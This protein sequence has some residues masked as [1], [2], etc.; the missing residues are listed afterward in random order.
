MATTEGRRTMTVA[1]LI[2]K[3]K[4]ENPDELV[5]VRMYA[6]DAPASH[7]DGSMVDVRKTIAARLSIRPYIARNVVQ[8]VSD[9]FTERW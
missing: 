8:L 7:Y 4:E 3:L 5:Q 1:E 9:E 2:E 6:T